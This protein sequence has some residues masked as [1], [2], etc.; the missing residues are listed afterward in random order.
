[1]SAVRVSEWDSLLFYIEGK[2]VAALSPLIPSIFVKFRHLII[3]TR[4]DI[5]GSK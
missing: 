3:L 4:N 1:M 2:L 5:E